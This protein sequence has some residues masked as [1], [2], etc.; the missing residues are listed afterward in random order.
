MLLAVFEG[1]SYLLCALGD[2]S[3]FYFI[4]DAM[5]GRTHVRSTVSNCM[6]D[7]YNL[8]ISISVNYVNVLA[9][10]CRDLYSSSG[11]LGFPQRIR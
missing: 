6:L 8:M 1:T 9:F 10:H 4:L 11:T 7:D 2:G 3:F 5:K